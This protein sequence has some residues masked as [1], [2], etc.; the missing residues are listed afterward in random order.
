M[1]LV[2]V[3]ETVVFTV[4]RS[5]VLD[6]ESGKALNIYKLPSSLLLRRQ[7]TAKRQCAIWD[8]TNPVEISAPHS[9]SAANGSTSFGHTKC[10]NHASG[11]HQ[12]SGLLGV[13]H[14]LKVGFS[15]RYRH[16]LFFS[17]LESQKSR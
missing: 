6:V 13:K 8:D 11:V 2:Y 15:R 4:E 17:R 7:H 5:S 1:C 16:F 9:K 3:Q 10:N 14:D 12:G